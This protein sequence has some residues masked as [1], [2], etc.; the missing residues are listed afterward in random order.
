MHQEA[1]I[2]DL[3]RVAEYAAHTWM[4]LRAHI[5]EVFFG[6]AR[7]IAEVL[8]ADDPRSP[9]DLIETT[10]AGQNVRR[11][12]GEADMS[13]EGLFVLFSSMSRR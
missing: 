9:F 1:P 7:A 13:A 5:E 3:E 8:R 10:F 12:S 4:T 2:G 11:V 6:N